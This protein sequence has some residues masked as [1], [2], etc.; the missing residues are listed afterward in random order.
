MLITVPLSLNAKVIKSF[1]ENNKIFL[2]LQFYHNGK[3]LDGIKAVYT[4]EETQIPAFSTQK[5]Y[6][7]Y[8]NPPKDGN[9]FV[10]KVVYG[11]TLYSAY[12]KDNA[13]DILNGKS[14]II[15]KIDKG[16]KP[17]YLHNINFNNIKYHTSGSYTIDCENNITTLITDDETPITDLK[18]L[19]QYLM[20]NLSSTNEEIS[21]PL[22]GIFLYSN[23]DYTARNIVVANKMTAT[24]NSGSPIVRITGYD[25]VATGDTPVVQRTMTVYNNGAFNDSYLS[26]QYLKL[27]DGVI[28]I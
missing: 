16:R 1:I 23:S 9:K 4:N 10:I 8:Y 17:M 22:S 6:C 27:T 24:Y 3:Q 2:V 25:S 11:N 12:I 14:E 20:D 18:V 28:E 5:E 7:V 26:G 19:A 21:I 13:T 15:F